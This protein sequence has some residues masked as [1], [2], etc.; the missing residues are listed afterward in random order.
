MKTAD[1]VIIGGGVIGSSIAWH[2]S[3]KGMKEILVI[4]KGSEAGSGSTGKATGGFRAQFGSEINIKLSMLSREKLLRFKDETGTDPGFQQ[5]GYIFLAA[6]E[7]ELAL[8]KEANQLQK[9]CGL[10]EVEL[11]SVEDIAK[12]IP[13]INTSGIIGGSLCKSDGFIS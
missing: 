12:I 7:N 11:V 3:S 10:T 5:N 8:L 4:D 1:A 2:L 13:H 9:S 6:S